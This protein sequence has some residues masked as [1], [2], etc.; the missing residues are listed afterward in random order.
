[1]DNN[2]S[3]STAWNIGKN[4]NKKA[5]QIISEIEKAGFKKLELNFMIP[6]D[7]LKELKKVIFS[8]DLQVISVHNFCPLP[9]EMNGQFSP[10]YF[11]VSSIDED[12]RKKAVYYA[13]KTVD[14]AVELSAKAVVLHSGRIDMPIR[15][16]ELIELFNNGKKFSDEYKQIIFEMVNERKEK[17]SIYLESAIKSIRELTK[18]AFESGIMI[19]IETRYY[20]REIPQFEEFEVIFDRIHEPNLV[21]WHDVGHAQCSQNLGITSHLSYLEKYSYRM[22]GIHLHDITGAEDHKLPGE[23]DFEFEMLKKYLNS[24]VIRVL[25]PHIPVSIERLQKSINY[26]KRKIGE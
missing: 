19:G 22:K 8:K 4:A 25:E 13:K 17:S 12:E 21:Y 14:T 6:E 26:L 7:L 15:Y 3:I 16:K 24:G 11:S 10:D 18:Y 2:Y 5:E 1:M 20:Y 23:G 9:A